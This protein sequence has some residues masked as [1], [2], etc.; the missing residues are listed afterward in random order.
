MNKEKIT[1]YFHKALRESLKTY[2]DLGADVGLDRLALISLGLSYFSRE[3]ADYS[4]KRSYPKKYRSGQS[5][6]TEMEAEEGVELKKRVSLENFDSMFTQGIHQQTSLIHPQNIV[7][8]HRMEAALVVHQPP[9]LKR[10][11]TDSEYY[12]NELVDRRWRTKEI[13]DRVRYA[14]QG[15]K[16]GWLM[17]D[18]VEAEAIKYHCIAA[19]DLSRFSLKPR[20]SEG[21]DKNDL[22]QR[23]IR[24]AEKD[25]TKAYEE[26]CLEY[27]QKKN[28]E[29]Q[30]CPGHYFLYPYYGKP[31][32]VLISNGLV[33]KAAEFKDHKFGTADVAQVLV[34]LRIFDLSAVITLQ[35]NQDKT[36]DEGEIRWTSANRTELA[37]R[38]TVFFK[39]SDS[40]N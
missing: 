18:S 1:G 14:R 28:S 23:I 12:I 15:D 9:K 7:P 17:D 11:K 20:S 37:D 33:V 13:F 38:T 39:F 24:S 35:Y 25:E 4:D 27:L 8:H 40:L 36:I 6:P 3:L 2:A 31:D 26:A 22:C 19:S 21:P 32:A 29:W 30:R 34:Y 10:K 5:T 16:V